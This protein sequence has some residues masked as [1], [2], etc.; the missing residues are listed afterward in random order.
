MK[1]LML[2]TESSN[3]TD[4]QLTALLSRII[5]TQKSMNKMIQYTILLIS[6][7]RK[8]KFGLSKLICLRW[9]LWW[10]KTSVIT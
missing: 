8:I 3:R 1:I 4:Y 10:Y 9:Y 7:I 6:C 5:N 2:V